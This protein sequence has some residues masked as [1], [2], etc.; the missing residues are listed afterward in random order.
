[1][2]RVQLRVR[3]RGKIV[4]RRSLQTRSRA[5]SGPSQ[6]AER[7]LCLLPG[8]ASGGLAPG[9]PRTPSALTGR[10]EAAPPPAGLGAR[11]RCSRGT[12]GRARLQAVGEA[13]GG[14][15]PA[16][17]RRPLRWGPPAGPCLSFFSVWWM[18]MRVI[19]H[20]ERVSL[21]FPCQPPTWA[22]LLL[23]TGPYPV[24]HISAASHL[25][26]TLIFRST[27]S[28]H[29]SQIPHFFRACLHYCPGPGKELRFL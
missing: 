24:A 9:S 11:A 29:E 3:G 21:A 19:N 13:G 10:L 20:R 5:G 12:A 28:S 7:K 26:R 15:A 1:M 14:G 2:A 23:Q 6:R 22:S 8:W 16:G 4:K 25:M 27:L 17:A 18:G